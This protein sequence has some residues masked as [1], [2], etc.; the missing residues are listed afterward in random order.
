LAAKFGSPPAYLVLPYFEG[1]TLRRLFHSSPSGLPITF[2]LGIIRQAAAAL[3]ALHALG[4][5]HGQV[6]PDHVIVSPQGHATL[7]DLT[8]ARRLE[9]SECESEIAMSSAPRYAAPEQ[10]TARRFITAAADVYSLGVMLYEALTGCPPFTALS[11]HDAARA[12]CR[13]IP[14]DLRLTRADASLEVSELC[15]RM[16]AK[17]PLRRPDADQVVR[18]LAELEIAEL[19]L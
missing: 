3:A 7:V 17:E 6:R 8:Q 14:L 12:H 13:E 16:L 2:A 19:A 11:P 9:S 4:W 10:G 5:L 18:W 1:V 15:Q